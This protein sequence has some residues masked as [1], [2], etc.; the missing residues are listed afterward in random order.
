MVVSCDGHDSE[1]KAVEYLNR[2]LV[3]YTNDRQRGNIQ[4]AIDLI[5]KVE[6]DSDLIPSPYNP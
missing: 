3:H 1:K 2:E 6:Y 5:K 4:K